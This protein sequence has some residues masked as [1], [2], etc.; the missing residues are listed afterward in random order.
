MA[1]QTLLHLLEWRQFKHPDHDFFI[2]MPIYSRKILALTAAL[3]AVFCWHRPAHAET[4]YQAHTHADLIANT[5]V[6]RPGESFWVGLRLRMDPDWHV[7]WKNPG[8]SGLAPVIE[9]DL[10]GGFKAKPMRWPFPAR[11]NV[12]PLTSF[13]YEHDVIFWSEIFPPSPLAEKNI[14]L[15]AKVKW[16]ACKVECIP[17]QADLAI[18]FPGPGSNLPHSQ[19]AA[20]LNASRFSWP[21][22]SDEWNVRA[23]E[24]PRQFVITLK[25][26]DPRRQI[27]D[28]IF[29]PQSDQLINHAASQTLNKDGKTYRLTVE[30][31]TLLKTAPRHLTGILVQANGW[32]K[33]GKYRALNIRQPISMNGAPAS[34]WIACW[35]ALVGG[36]ILNFMPCVL[37]VLSLK[38]L[39]LVKHAHHRR[40]ILISG[41]LFGA[42]VLVSF[43]ILAGLLIIL[44]SAGHQLGWGFQF[45]APGFVTFMAVLLF[46]MAINLLGAFEFLITLPGLPRISGQ[47]YGANFLSGVL[48]TVVATPCTAPFMGTAIGFALG[49]PSF[50]ALV[51][52]TFLG[53]GLA[54]PYILLCLFPKLLRFIPKP[55]PWMNVLKI[56]LGILL[57]ACVVWLVWVYELQKGMRPVLTLLAGLGLI[58]AGL[59][60]WG[61]AQQGR[62]RS[63]TWAVILCAAGAVAAAVSIKMPTDRIAG[64]MKTAQAGV[65]WQD[66]SAARLAEWRAANR[67]VLID[68]TAAWCL[69]CQVNDRLVFQNQKVVET[70]KKFGIIGLQADWTSYDPQITQALQ[71][72]DKNS[73]PLYVFYAPGENEATILPE[74]I[75][76]EYL[77]DVL[78]GRLDK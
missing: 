33:D 46:V 54:G 31:S 48:A 25:A 40:E 59:R 2:P 30:K 18:Q 6:V 1:G 36:V 37:P 76:V 71:G 73:I 32:D 38:I 50:S 19:H 15:F 49:Q 60:G 5:A 44:K 61:L 45:Q 67:P 17:G 21:I 56:L 35:L 4:I 13:G 63:M 51:I 55:G 53:L 8:D 41:L 64:Q 42:G 23:H 11:I 52:F 29:F 24:T 14:Q 3:L 27:R 69:T 34:L 62:N 10:P 22:D 39:G 58:G 16:L 47:G 78:H 75:T 57:L 74:L 7:Y 68:F 77:L 65:P 43:W 28:L 9:W 12:G 70:F 20:A 72:Y 66:F 26:G